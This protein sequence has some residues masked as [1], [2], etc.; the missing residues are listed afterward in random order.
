MKLDPSWPKL[1]KRAWSVRLWALA[2]LILILEPLVMLAV[3]LSDGWNLAVQVTLRLA[4]SLLG[5]AGIW[6]RVI[7]Q[8]EFEG[9]D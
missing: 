3:E 1:L 4:G 9:A 5:I 6:A 7:K 2:S 8:K